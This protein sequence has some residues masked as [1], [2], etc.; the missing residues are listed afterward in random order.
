MPRKVRWHKPDVQLPSPFILW[1]DKKDLIYFNEVLQEFVQQVEEQLGISVE[2][3]CATNP[4]VGFHLTLE[5]EATRFRHNQGY[6]LEISSNDRIEA[7]AQLELLLESKPYCKFY[8][9]CG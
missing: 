7:R 3:S 2:L 5:A 6:R 9:F 8:C 1:L 4:P